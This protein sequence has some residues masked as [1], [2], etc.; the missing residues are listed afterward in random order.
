M[1][2]AT[3]LAK[4]GMAILNPGK[5][6]VIGADQPLYSILKQL[7]W[8]FSESELGENS[9]FCDDGGTPHWNGISGDVWQMDWR[10]CVGR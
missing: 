3:I 8:Q 7:Q 6:L 9:F 1:K 5:T 2:H 10:F 4:D